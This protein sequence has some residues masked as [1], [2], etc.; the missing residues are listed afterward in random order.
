MHTRILVLI[1]LCL[2]AA[3]CAA[4]APT[5]TAQATPSIVA[6][7]IA[8]RKSG[9]LRFFDLAN[10]DVRDIPMLMALDDLQ[11]Q[12]Y[13]IDRQ[14]LATSTLIVD[15]LVRGDADIGLLND[16]TM[17]TAIAKGAPVRTFV[18]FTGSTTVM[19]AKQSLGSCSELDG[20]RLGV[21]STSGTSPALLNL[22]LKS[23]CNGAKPQAVII[24]DSA[25][26]T[27]ALLVGELD[28]AMIPGEDSF[29]LEKQAPGKFH[30]LVAYSKEYPNVQVD[31][32][33]VRTDWAAKNPTLVKDFLQALLSANRRVIASPQLLY[34]ESV[35]RLG[36]DAETAEQIGNSHLQ[37][38]IWS[39]NGGLTTD[40]VQSTIDFLTSMG[41]LS[42]GLKASDVADLS[43]LNAVLDEIGRQ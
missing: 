4:P 16:Q 29:S 40:N 39:A 20:K 43:Y 36:L 27:A 30:A 33:H 13:S 8:P 35:K 41:A 26:R 28:A 3:G 37:L 23:T 15:A 5:P 19:M 25:A 17:W 9:A 11:A 32:L 22:Y 7:T 2:V 12:G 1:L 42:P 14:Y 31:G 18:Q 34:D 10:L 38:G 6:S 24:T 21:A